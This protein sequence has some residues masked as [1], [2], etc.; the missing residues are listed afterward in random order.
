MC[1]ESKIIIATKRLFLTEFSTEIAEDF[2]ELNADQEVMRFT[3]DQAFNSIEESRLFLANYSNYN[4]HG[5]GR[6]SVY[7]KIDSEWIGWCGLRKNDNGLIDIG[8]RFHRRFW[9]QGFGTEA[10][11]ACLDYA[12]RTLQ[13]EQVIARSNSSNIGSLRIIKNLSLL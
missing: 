13:I 7:T 3:G 11:K 5:F 4:D 2:Y 10:A 8:F 1:Q 9:N 12:F 6:W